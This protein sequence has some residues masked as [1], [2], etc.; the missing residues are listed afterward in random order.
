MLES[1][2]DDSTGEQLAY[3]AELLFEAGALDVGFAPL[4]MKKGRC[5]LMIGIRSP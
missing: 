3:L 2:V 5:C 4:L 1:H